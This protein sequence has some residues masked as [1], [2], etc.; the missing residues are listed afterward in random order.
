IDSLFLQQRTWP[1]SVWRE[2]YL[3]HPLVGTLARRILWEFT[4][5]KKTTT[6]IWFNDKLVDLDL[7]PVP[8]NAATTVQLWH[9]IGKAAVEVTAWRGW[10]DEQQVQ[11]PFKQAHREIYLLTD[12]ERR[13]RT[14]SNRYA[15]HVLKQHQFNALCALRGWKNQ[16]RLMVDADYGP[17]SLH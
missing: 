3:D 15:A 8:S 5:E 9:P 14:Y 7:K 12:A 2:R 1:F 17:P 16:L 4:T 11:Q 6:G 13:T 10:L